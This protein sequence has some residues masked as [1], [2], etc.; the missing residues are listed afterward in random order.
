[1][2]LDATSLASLASR[3]SAAGF[4]AGALASTAL[5]TQ[6]PSSLSNCPLGQFVPHARPS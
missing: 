1:V 6:R 5:G 3:G 2:L 4:G